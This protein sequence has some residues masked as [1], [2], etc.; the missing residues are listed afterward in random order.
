MNNNVLSAL[1]GAAVATLGWVVTYFQQQWSQRKEEQRDFLRR[2]VE[3]FY[4]PLLALVQQKL[5]VQQAQDERMKT[6]PG[7]DAWVK[8][9]RFFQDN[10]IVPIMSAIAQLLRTKSYLAFDWPESFEKYLEH[11][12]K[13]VALYQL[14][15]N[16]D[17]P[18]DV[19]TI[20]WPE[21]L[22]G[23]VKE[24]KTRLEERLRKLY[25]VPISSLKSTA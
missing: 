10:Q 21:K 22:A 24:R 8:T 14:W 16:T 19:V 1:I 2:Q 4:A 6:V 17:I 11:E 5:F 25:G 18:G 7:G 13:S 20:P 23:D 15:R 9:L 3:E 12:A